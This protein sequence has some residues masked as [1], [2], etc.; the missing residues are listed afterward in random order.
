MDI[1]IQNAKLSD[2][3]DVFPLFKQLWPFI[4]LNEESLEKMFRVILSGNRDFML[5][6]FFENKVNGFIAGSFI[7]DFWHAGLVC[8]VSTLIVDVSV[9]KC[10]IGTALMNSVKEL[11]IH[12]QCKA[13]EL[14][15]AFHREQTHAFYEKYGFVKRAFT[16]SL[17]L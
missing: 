17:E 3:P 8:H 16:F 14:D 15:S 9:R 2:L 1:L 12:N 5:C 4:E 10:N 11:A 7:N 6:S 13:I